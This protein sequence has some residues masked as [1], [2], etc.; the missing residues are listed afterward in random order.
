M[1]TPTPWLNRG[2]HRSRHGN[3]DHVN[4]FPLADAYRRLQPGRLQVHER[5][6]TSRFPW[7]ERHVQCV[8][9][10]DLWRPAALQTAA[11]E[12]VTVKD[13]G[14]WNLEAGPDFLGATLIIGPDQRQI[15]GDIEV[16]L[17]PAD[18]DRHQHGQDPAYDRVMAHVTYFPGCLPSS[19]LPVG[20]VQIPLKDALAAIPRFS[21]DAI[22][23]SAYPYAARSRHPPCAQRLADWTPDHIGDLLDASG[24]ERLR[25]K[26]DR[27]AMAIDERGPEQ[28]LYED[29]LC[30]LGYKNNR[31]PFR[32][33]AELVPLNVL[34]DESK[35]NP[36]AA[37]SLLLGVAGLLP[38]Q[39]RSQWDEETRTFIRQLWDFWW[40]HQDAWASRMLDKSE[41]RLSGTRPPNHPHRRLMAAALLFAPAQSLAARLATIPIRGDLS[42]ISVVLRT[43][44]PEAPPYWQRRLAFSGKPQI[45]PVALIG[46]DRATSILIN[47]IVPYLAVLGG[48]HAAASAAWQHLPAEQ[49][50]AVVRRTA[51]VL[52]GRDHNPALYRAGLRQQGLIQIFQDFCLNDRSHCERCELIAHLNS[53]PA[54]EWAAS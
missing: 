13:P 17:H 10:D 53:F 40:T 38:A 22:D 36:I 4:L 21:F 2:Q 30:A 29:V 5:R 15:Q 37:Y 52:L 49:D 39:L 42:W 8:W 11:G 7:T 48:P 6:V 47:V 23:L 33:L 1:G 46:D 12:S 18:W 34:R 9:Y 44:Q 24:Q 16:H 20:A 35:H 14:Q 27:L 43:L 19:A 32:H 3:S 28:A 50:N 45:G 26:T 31:A 41:W 51:H 25:R 54:A